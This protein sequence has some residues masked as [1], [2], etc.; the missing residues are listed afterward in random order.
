MDP[1]KEILIVILEHAFNKQSWH[2]TNLRGALRGL[3]LKEV[4]FRPGKNRHNIWEITLHCAYWKY[5]VARKL[6]DG[7][8][9]EFPRKPSNWPKISSNPS[10]EE[11]K[12]DIS[13]LEEQHKQLLESIKSFD[14]KTLMN[15]IPKSKWIYFDLISGI[16]AH[17]LYHTG[18]IQLIKRLLRN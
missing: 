6:V 12:K 17:D 4:L 2:G 10:L 14:H 1:E 13:L 11:W 7:K 9:G 5:I 8:R 16:A 3:N 15:K 18:Q